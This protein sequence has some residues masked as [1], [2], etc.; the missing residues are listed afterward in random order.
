MPW[1][2]YQWKL[3]VSYQKLNQV[4]RLFDLS[5]PRCDDAVKNIDIK[6]KYFIAVDIDSGYWKVVEEEKA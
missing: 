2:E 4:T 6:S 1:N 5:I 3:Y